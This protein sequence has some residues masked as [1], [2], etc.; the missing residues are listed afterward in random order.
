[1]PLDW[2]IFA[3]SIAIDAAFIFIS[4]FSYCADYWAARPAAMLQLT[5]AAWAFAISHYATFLE[6]CFS[7]LA[8]YFQPHDDRL[9]QPQMSHWLPDVFTPWL[10]HIAPRR[11]LASTESVTPHCHSRH[12]DH[13]LPPLSH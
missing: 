9:S 2:D 7:P 10:S 6:I 1:M 4:L 12:Y 13:S 11:Q 3:I 8:F 5:P